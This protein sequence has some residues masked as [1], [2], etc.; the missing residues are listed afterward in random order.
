MGAD[1]EFRPETYEIG[2]LVE[3]RRNS[4]LDVNQEYQRGEVWSVT[5]QQKLID[6]LL[7]GYPIPLL[8]FHL[9][10]R[11]AAGLSKENFEI[12]DGQQ[13]LEAIYKFVE[14]AWSLLDPQK[15]D[16]KAKFPRFVKEEPCSWAGR[17]F[18]G[19]SEELQSRFLRTR[20]SVV[21]I[22]T[23]NEHEVR[24][25]FVRLQSGLPLNAQE[26]RDS[27]PGD[28][29]DFILWLGGKP[30]IARYP[31]HPFFHEVLRM[32]PSSDR[33][34]TRQLAAQLAMIHLYRSE[35]ERRSFP[36]INS[37]QVTDFY[38]SNIDFDRNSP[39]A[40]RLVDILNILNDLLRGK[41]RP[42]LHAHDAIH[43]VALAG[44]LWDDYTPSW[45][46]NLPSALDKF[47]EGLAL[48]NKDSESA[49]PNE[50][51][52]RYGQWTRT[53]SDRGDRI[54]TRHR[55]YVE[56]MLPWL[57]PVPKD[58]KRAYGTLERVLVYYSRNKKCDSCGGTVNWDDAEL[59]HVRP[60]SQ[61]GETTTENAALV[62]RDCH[63]KS[64]ADVERFAKK[65]AEERKREQ[66]EMQKQ[67]ELREL[68]DSIEI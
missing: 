24:D 68:A 1:M 26:T 15:D 23:H 14:G 65:F 62:H 13:R 22:E 28:F 18:S 60:H 66:R 7:R 54:E 57:K 29:T 5:Q 25:L 59:H 48:G 44:D 56:K 6:S 55:F 61:G 3:L 53:N 40:K 9:R 33:G 51:W 32:K 11:A 58:E 64:E 42:K 63:P 27:W 4:M 30:S 16:K 49:T 35:N 50:Y 41:D 21:V 45:R 43:L 52:T 37:A 19:L 67:R 17:A 10:R 2:E 12:V 20:L 36:D 47:Q 38:Y 46:D 8:Y 34:K 31:G 39:E